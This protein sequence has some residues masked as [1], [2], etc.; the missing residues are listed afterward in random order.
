MDVIQI[1]S[2]C[3]KWDKFVWDSPGGTIFSTLRFLSYHP[4]SRF[5]FQNLA[6]EDGGRL[7][8][9]IAGGGVVR[10]G[11]KY[12]RSPV[13]ASF[14][15]FVLGEGCSLEAVLEAVG[16]LTAKIESLGYAGIEM[17]GA[18]A[19]YSA[20]ED[21]SLRF[22]LGKTGYR[23]IAQDATLVIDLDA[24]DKDDLDP[25]LARNLRKAEKS[26]V[27]VQVATELGGFYEV[28]AANLA[29]KGARPT[30]TLR[31]L[32]HLLLLFPDRLILVE[33]THEGKVVGGCLVIVCNSRVGLA[34]YI[35]DDRRYSQ[36]R[37]AETT[38]FGAASLLQRMGLR[39]FDLGTVS[40]GDEV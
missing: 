9:V 12:F 37:V 40:M 32:E 14:G 16:A 33:A 6:V 13:G 3:D 35:C 27:R 11:R 38:L 7:V 17:V 18:P 29:A 21:Q 25:V 28:L 10:E 39:Y 34:F 24:L 2:P 8:G 20:R 22:A 4:R 23:I 5:E 1:D 26:G 19:C 30:H 36:M 31:E 15:G